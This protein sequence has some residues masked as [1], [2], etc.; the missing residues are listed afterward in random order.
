MHRQPK[1]LCDFVFVKN[2]WVPG[3]CLHGHAACE[4]YPGYIQEITSAEKPAATGSC[5]HDKRLYPGYWLVHD[6]CTGTCD[7]SKHKLAERAGV[8]FL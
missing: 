7:S 5:I 2:N 8:T 3:V 6:I 1:V 4:V